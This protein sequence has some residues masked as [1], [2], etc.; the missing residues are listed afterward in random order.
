M[1]MDKQQQQTA[2]NNSSAA[3]T[4]SA[5]QQKKQQEGI[6]LIVTNLF[7][8]L[9]TSKVRFDFCHARVQARDHLPVLSRTSVAL[10]TVPP[11]ARLPAP[12]PIAQVH[13]LLDLTE[14]VHFQAFAQQP[15]YRH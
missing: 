15:C 7:L 13:R 3:K 6:L 10:R 4:T 1:D 11:T 9:G 5:A 12:K 2:A 8:H 14:S